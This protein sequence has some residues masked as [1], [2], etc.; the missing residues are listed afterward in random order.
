MVQNWAKEEFNLADL[1]DERLKQRL[2]KLADSFS[3]SPESPINHAC[4]DWS[5]TKAAYRFFSNENIS[6]KGILESHVKSTLKRCSQHSTILAI[7]DTGFFNYTSHKKTKGLGSISKT[8]GKYRDVISYGITMHS[9]LALDTEG[10]PLG[11]LDQKIYTKEFSSQERKDIKQKGYYNSIPIRNKDS[12]K[13][14][15]T[16]MN[17][18]NVF[19]S[20]NTTTVTICDREADIYEFFRFSSKIKSP[21]LVRANH[22]RRVNKS[23][24]YS[25]RSGKKLWSILRL[26][27]PQGQ[28]TIKIP[29]RKDQPARKTRCNVTFS[30]FYLNPP[31]KFVQHSTE[32]TPDLKLY[33]IH[34]AEQKFPK[35]GEPIDW[36]LI[37][38]I[39]IKTFK[40][41]LEK[42]RWY[43]YRWR[44]E[45]FHK[46]LKSGLKVEDCRLSTSERLSRYLALMSIVAWRITI[47]N[48]IFC[49][50]K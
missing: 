24:V 20:K 5:Q 40:E 33:A 22:D 21:V 39:P 6:Y 1:G 7:Q 3:K 14:F 23:S 35:E 11:I 12:D 27:K 46:I 42:I 8:E 25:K 34:V 36:M 45:I 29:K 47:P 49:L 30:E 31:A 48:G 26:T 43:C 13:W 41:A 19:A 17:S 38:N 2:I 15:E 50:P 28:I 9:C 4:K 18:Y 37:T 16:L 32:K 44:I 10:L